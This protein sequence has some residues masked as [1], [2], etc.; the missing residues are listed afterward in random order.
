LTRLAIYIANIHYHK[1][2]FMLRINLL[3]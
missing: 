1:H 3:D 2:Y